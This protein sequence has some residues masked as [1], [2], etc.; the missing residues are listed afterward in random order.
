VGPLGRAIVAAVV[1]HDYLSGWWTRHR[2]NDIADAILLVESRDY[3]GYT[4]VAE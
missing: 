2:A 1:D 4:R 3:D